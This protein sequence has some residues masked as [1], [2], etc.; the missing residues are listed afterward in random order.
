MRWLV[1]R[2]YVQRCDRELGACGLAPAKRSTFDPSRL[3]AQESAVARLVAGGMSNRQVAS[4]L[5]VSVKTVQFHL[6]H[7]YAKVGV[8]SRAELA[9]RLRDDTAADVATATLGGPVTVSG[10]SR[11]GRA[12]AS[13][14][15]GREA[16]DGAP[17]YVNTVVNR[18]LSSRAW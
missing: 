2:P 12:R 15:R 14:H 4:E 1:A 13:G 18:S 16:G 9:A 7:I 3:T 6:T 10:R 5:F 11:S 8:G 17:S